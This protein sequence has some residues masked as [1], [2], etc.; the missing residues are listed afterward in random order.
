MKTMELN[1]M[2]VSLNE[3]EEKVMSLKKAAKNFLKAMGKFAKATGRFFIVI[4]PAYPQY[5]ESLRR[6]NN[7]Q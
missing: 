3:S 1:P 2:A 7:A 5:M 4:S 6:E